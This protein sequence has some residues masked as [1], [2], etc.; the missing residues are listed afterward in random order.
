MKAT[1]VLRDEHE[2]VRVAMQILGKICD[3]IEAGEDF[4]VRHLEQ[5]LDF[6]R[7]FTDKCH[8]GKEEDLLFPAMEEIGIPSEGG[9]VGVMLSEHETMREYIRNF[10]NALERYGA[11]DESAKDDIVENVR[12]YLQWLDGH[13]EKENNILFM[14][15]DSH[16][17]ADKQ[18]ELYE[19]FETLEEERIGKDVHE[20]FHQMLHELA[21]HYLDSN[22]DR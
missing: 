16:L 13:I 7:V 4:E 1:D 21:K 9:P 15:A 20:Q 3:R 2:A 17:S 14:M 19:A 5:L 22:D 8:H 11:G 6:I 18:E 10:A 12:T